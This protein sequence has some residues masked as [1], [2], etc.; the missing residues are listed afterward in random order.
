MWNEYAREKLREIDED[1]RRHAPLH[2]SAMRIS[3]TAPR[4]LAPVV[5]FA[6]S[7][8]RRLGEAIESW[9]TPCPDMHRA[10]DTR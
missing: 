4:P 1:L 9:A 5:R 3:E 10:P 8:L 7:R 6:G 2:T